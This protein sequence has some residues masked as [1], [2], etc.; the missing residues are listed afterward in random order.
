MPLVRIYGFE[1]HFVF[2]AFATCFLR[3]SN[4]CNWSGKRN[5]YSS[6]FFSFSFSFFHELI[7]IWQ[8]KT[9]PVLL[10]RNNTTKYILQ[11]LFQDVYA[12]TTLNH[13]LY[14]M[15]SAIFSCISRINF[16]MLSTPT[17]E[18]Y[19]ARHEILWG[20]KKFTS[21]IYIFELHTVS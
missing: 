2:N 20:L 7:I 12:V 4:K 5:C 21:V 19:R 6:F 8:N 13:T 9:L 10:F 18:F 1:P 17:R 11:W 3:L 16:R 15:S 14:L